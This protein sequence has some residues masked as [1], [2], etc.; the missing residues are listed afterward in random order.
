[1][2]EDFMKKV[3]DF[4][5]IFMKVEKGVPVM[6][7]KQKYERTRMSYLFKLQSVFRVGGV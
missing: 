2:K 6:W 4:C 1:M 3:V 5:F 7:N